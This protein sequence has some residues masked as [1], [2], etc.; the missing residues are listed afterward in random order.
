MHMYRSE[1]AFGS[2]SDE[3]LD[4]A[5]AIVGMSCR[6]SGAR[7]PAEYW[8]NIRAG[9]ES[10][11]AYSE[12]E[13]LAAGVTRRELSDAN[14]V[15]VGAPIDDMEWFDAG[16][17]GLSPRD[18][19]VMDPQHRHFL[20]CAWEALEDA[21][22]DPERFAGAIGVFAGSGHNAYFARNLLSNPSLVRNVGP[23]LLR[24]TGNDKDFMTTR[25]SYL[26]DLRGPSVNV[27]TA[28]STSL[29]A[30]HLA[31]QQL[32]ND[33]C[34]MAIAGGVS[35][36]LPHRHGY[37]FEEGGILSPDGHCRPFDAASRG[38]VF[39]SGI[40]LVVLRRLRDA[41]AD[42]DNI[43]A[44]IRGTAINNDG[45][46]KVGYLA[47]S[48]D[49]QAAVIAEA[50]DVADVPA[51]TIG[52][53]E[54]HGT[55]TPVGD[56]IEVAALT[57]AFR[58]DTDEVGFCAL[59][60]VKAN[61]GHTDTAA[62]TASL[63][64]VTLALQNRE[65]PP[66]IN[67]TADNPA[68]ALDDSPF[69]VNAAL[70]PWGRL[71][72]APL[73]A[74]VSSLGVG[75]TNAHVIVE[76]APSRPA[77]GAARSHHLLA[78]SGASLRA[79]EGN[80]AAIGG[81]F[82]A[83]PGLDRGDVSYTLS[84]GRRAL[85]KRSVLVVDDAEDVA[86]A[87]VQPE[88]VFTADAVADR[89]V[90]FMFCGAGSQYVAMGAKLYDTEPVF[91]ASVDACIAASEIDFGRWLFP[92]AQDA[93]QAALEMERPSIALPALFT[94]QVA[95]AR[96]WQS[97]GVRP[98]GMIGHS[99]GEYAAAH[100]A[101]VI[102]L[103]DALRIVWMRGRLFETLPEGGMLSV[104]LPEDALRRM[105]P[106]HLSIAAINGASLC[107]VS[108]TI[109]AIAAFEQQLTDQGVETRRV[110]IA[111]AAHSSM[112]DPL[113]AEFRECLKAVR[114]NPPSLPFVSNLTGTWI[115]AE[116][117]RDPEYWVRHLRQT[118][119]FTDG[120]QQLLANPTD[121]LLEV[122]PGRTMASLARQ[123]PGRARAQPVLTS[124]RHPDEAVDDIAHLLATVGR[125]W[126]LG[127]AFDWAGYWADQ[128]RNRLALPTYSFDRERYWIEPGVAS[129]GAGAVDDGQ[130]REPDVADWFYEPVWRRTSTLPGAIHEG[131]A[132]VFLDD[133]GIGCSLA[134]Q[135]R[136]AGRKVVTVRAGR[137]FRWRGDGFIV[138]PVAAADYTR[139]LSTL[140]GS[141]CVPTHIYHC[142]LVTGREASRDPL[143]STTFCQDHG[144]YGLM[145]L[146][147]GW[148]EEGTCPPLRI[149]MISNGMQRVAGETRL[150][151]AKATILGACRVIA[152]EYPDLDV[153]SIDLAAG[154]AYD[155]PLADLILAEVAGE[156]CSVVS[157]RAGER[158]IQAFE[159]TARSTADESL[160]RGD[161]VY[162]I[163]G[164]LGG[165]GL[166]IGRH[167]AAN[168]NARVALLTRTS[169]PP[170]ATWE[171][172]LA[173]A[174]LDDSVGDR[175]RAV[176]AIEAAGGTVMLVAADV[177]DR[178]AVAAAVR[179]VRARFGRIDGV[180]HTAGVLADEL[181]QLKTQATA[182]SVLAPKL[183]G[184]L[185]LE[186]ALAD[187]PPDFIMLF[188]SISAFAGLAGQV[189]YAAA[190]S[191][192]DAFAQ[193]RCTQ[194][195]PRVISVGW[196]KWLE[197]GMAAE[198]RRQQSDAAD[199]MP[200]D[201]P[202]LQRVARPAPHETIV[203]GRFSPERDWLL[204]EHRLADGSPLMP[205][206]GYIELVRAAFAEGGVGAVE[207]R[208]VTF[209]TPFAVREGE[210]RDMRIH[211]RREEERAHFLVDGR[212]TS[213][214]GAEW[215]HHA[216]G[217][218]QPL[219]ATP[220]PPIDFTEIR[221]RCGAAANLR[222]EQSPFLR[223]G[224][225]WH[226]VGATTL[227]ESEALLELELPAPYRSDL[228]RILVHPALLDFATA[229]AQ[230]LVSENAHGRFLV[231]LSYGRVRLWG[232]LP[233]RIVSHIRFRGEET[234]GPDAAV[235]D[236]TITDQHG[237][238]L[239]EIE[240]FTMIVVRGPALLPAT[241]GAAGTHSDGNGLSTVEGLA[242]LDRVLAGAYRPHLIV[243]PEN[244]T[245]AVA[246][247]H[248]VVRTAAPRPAKEGAESGAPRNEAEMLIAQ[249]WGEMLGIDDVRHDDD[250]FDLGGHSLLAVQFI[251]RLRKRTGK[252]VSLSA[253][254]ERPTVGR[255]AALIDPAGAASVD[256]SPPTK[257]TTDAATTKSLPEGI[258]LL[259][260][261]TEPALFLV[262]DGLGET[263]LYR[264]LALGLSGEQAVYGLEPARRGNG[265]FRHTTI[266]DMARAYI[267]RIRQVQPE[268]PYLL[269][270]L[271][272][273]GVIAFEMA[274]RLQD[275]GVCV[276]F[277]G[278][279]DAADVDAAPR[280]F[281]VVR[282][283]WQGLTSAGAA[284]GDGGGLVS[285]V[286]RKT[287]N[288][289]RWEI[290]SRV[291]RIR[292]ARHVE[293]LARDEDALAAQG[294]SFLQVYEV[295]HRA[296]QMRGLFAV[297]EV[298]LFRA[299]AGN[300]AEDDIPFAEK[301]SDRILG[302]GKR[303]A[304]DVTLVEVPG[305]HTSLLQLPHVEHLARVL[306]QQIDAA[307]KR[308]GGAG[309][310]EAETANPQE[311][312]EDEA[313]PS[314][315]QVA[316]E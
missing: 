66:S 77:S 75:G 174:P 23:F 140:L 118:V 63:I 230:A 228:D 272:A 150:S 249:L 52:Y 11:R 129:T 224:P 36:E 51:R 254:L 245:A 47:P 79:L 185:A 286:W 48:L 192:L 125:L 287:M 206:T 215:V 268:G 285:V 127:V 162:L 164:G 221:E 138:N 62:G 4:T 289:L 223:F 80:C 235:F 73:R 54:A 271:C 175:I 113:L 231:P 311:V 72:D 35:L 266:S 49:G 200:F 308:W 59:G 313:V 64:K 297:G 135:L 84:T 102:D 242:A 229:G 57:A 219:E 155:A 100:I 116:E 107:V 208:D 83:Q 234:D 45:S 274:R 247:L 203:S 188:S 71:E 290:N 32:L 197:V 61:I 108:G 198:Q 93:A 112:L 314:L 259:R 119:R 180:F 12:E 1:D 212:G 20:E 299:T 281:Y 255:L 292:M 252:A 250:F 117:T 144:F 277:V 50:L 58:R 56:P 18:A 246:R 109:E 239:V 253:L 282:K 91:R 159:R 134:E 169:L 173:E 70:R 265:T 158:W 139:L 160:L 25:A 115:T 261:G 199:S 193:A 124:M 225:R 244:V 303:V 81:A 88:R 177:T 233:A 167:L 288:A 122:G 189:D 205:G 184:T 60:S 301:F 65:L 98:T 226:N 161:G 267:D 44:V 187:A 28:C 42:R 191:F 284:A 31:V 39:G 95:L 151:P 217:D 270:G 190:N 2:R 204:D 176:L 86:A 214:A 9:I 316:A 26:L 19:A 216:N 298:V 275:M 179:K 24:H 120:L 186:R 157:Y 257:A 87:L 92:T 97:W 105:L 280:R 69:C 263:L 104:P 152:R 43:R 278:I 220:P 194:V 101:G 126:A 195:Q 237:T 211:L 153:R 15:R 131:C 106:P 149:A 90:A 110:A 262:H 146:A 304:E 178:R 147:Q 279:M 251:N 283:R 156:P 300:G 96:L 302:W 8:A 38:T 68:C 295:A 218:I 29:V 312:R 276:P 14:Y 114:L 46:G 5:I 291:D 201:H 273:G 248:P 196:S 10:V 183:Y 260:P 99:S 243:S 103:P 315:I 141:G 154:E 258:V 3:M 166:A 89:S 182:R 256:G 293:T 168:Y 55:G 148:A 121:V 82:S 7:T 232:P 17:F 210:A 296:H 142:W 13:L 6:F 74:G 34:D 40:G 53:V 22:H 128:Q 309:E 143:R 94:V 209:L 33:E 306:Q 227:G 41:I 241:E 305:G 269:A 238:V 85:G 111:V 222:P 133:E 163:T 165:I 30:V 213:G 181:T 37:V 132:L 130:G 170:R 67:Y 136:A 171:R 145:A 172:H 240:A 21:G 123:H 202:F 264:S 236:V 207:L 137:G 307:L 27:Q 310:R 76:E 16:L 78:V 294:L